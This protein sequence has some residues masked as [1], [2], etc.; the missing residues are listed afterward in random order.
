MMPNLLTKIFPA[1]LTPNPNMIA[2]LEILWSVDENRLFEREKRTFHGWENWFFPK[3]IF[4]GNSDFRWFRQTGRLFINH[5]K[6]RFR[7]I[8]H[9][10]I[11][12]DNHRKPMC[13][14]LNEFL[15]RSRIF[16]MKRFKIFSNECLMNYQIYPSSYFWQ[17]VEKRVIS[18]VYGHL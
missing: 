9:P 7:W 8:T 13:P 16:E 18:K 2:P 6:L 4:A 5:R 11:L 10:E 14:E 12:P 1:S 3:A 15:H 17:I